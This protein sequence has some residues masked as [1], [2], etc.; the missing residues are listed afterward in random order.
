MVAD[1]EL[2]CS[3]QFLPAILEEQHLPPEK[4]NIEVLYQ[5]IFK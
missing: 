4:Q 1:I 5:I 2:R 3:I